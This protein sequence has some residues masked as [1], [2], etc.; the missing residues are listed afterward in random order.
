MALTLNN[1]T[2]FETQ[3]TEEAASVVSSPAV[4]TTDPRF[5]AAHLELTS[6][7]DS[8]RL[9]WVIG[10]DAGNDYIVGVAIKAPDN[11]SGVGPYD[12]IVVRDSGPATVLSLAFKTGNEIL[13]RDAT[14]A[15][16]RTI[17]AALSTTEYKYFEIYFQHSDPGTIE[18]FIDDDSQ[19]EDTG[20]DLT[21]GNS[22]DD[23]GRLSLDGS[24]SATIRFDDV[25]ILSGATSASDRLG[26]WAVKTN[27]STDVGATDQGDT[28]ADGTWA[29]VSETPGNSGT[30]NDAQ[31]QDT[32]NLTGS[33][34]TDGGDRPGPSG[35]SDVTGAT[36]VGAKYISNLMRGA[37]GGREHKIL[38]G[39]SGDGV[40]AT[41]NLG[42]TT[43]FIIYEVLSESASIVP[44]ESEFMQMGFSKDL[45]GGQDVFCGDQW[46]M[47]G[48]V[49][50]SGIT[51]PIFDHHY[52]AMRAR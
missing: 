42:L 1:F 40:T 19:G 11:T 30:S 38:Y 41:A 43:D 27:Q 14:G 39:N 47:L 49:P 36:I 44:T 28:L 32:G 23:T 9:P 48:Y 21:N 15:T 29:L 10:T 7:S 2:G 37:G 17:G 31:Y 50:A 46:A 34:I 13:V 24:D 35:D 6:N 51:M 5:G 52:R 26:N 20:Q 22:L 45:T 25:Y 33:T 4:V 3:G 18:V 8:Y 12:L 16:I